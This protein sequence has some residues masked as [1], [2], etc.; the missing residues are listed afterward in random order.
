LRSFT[1]GIFLGKVELW[2]FPCV[3][4]LH[5]LFAARHLQMKKLV[6]FASDI[7]VKAILC[8]S[9][10]VLLTACGA[11]VTDSANGQQLQTAAAVS[12]S[13]DQSAA[14]SAATTPNAADAAVATA[15]EAAP[16]ASSE[17]S[18]NDGVPAPTA[19][20]PAAGDTSANAPTATPAT[21]YIYAVAPAGADT[22]GGTN[23]AL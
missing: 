4:G 14:T 6:T 13:A 10:A 11:G 8:C 9:A 16:G 21:T 22:E 2:L 1:V 20:S 18:A 23:A 19:A 5:S 17:P 15:T 3:K 12:S 7:R